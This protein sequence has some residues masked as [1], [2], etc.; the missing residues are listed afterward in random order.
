MSL[1]PAI[2]VDVPANR[3]SIERVIGSQLGRL[4]SANPAISEYAYVLR[5]PSSKVVTS[6]EITRALR[7]LSNARG[8]LLA[9]GYD[10]TVEAREAAAKARCDIIS[11]KE[12]GWTDA[13]YDSTR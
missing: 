7:R 5:F 11:E 13:I 10:F 9:A 12:F 6:G 3:A 2:T 8:A 1:R 4:F